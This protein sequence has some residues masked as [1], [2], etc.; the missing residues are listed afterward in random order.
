[1]VPENERSFSGII[2]GNKN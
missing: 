1:M 2:S